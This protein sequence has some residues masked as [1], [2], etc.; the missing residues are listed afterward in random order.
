[1]HRS[2]VQEQATQHKCAR[3]IRLKEIGCPNSTHLGP[4]QEIGLGGRFGGET[5]MRSGHRALRALAVAVSEAFSAITNQRLCFPY[6][7]IPFHLA[8]RPCNRTHLF[9]YTTIFASITGSYYY[10]Y[11][12]LI[13]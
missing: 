1:M 9:A 6:P 3:R 11:Y 12:I 2:T 13:I 4:R 5:P 7:Q 10:Y 8:D